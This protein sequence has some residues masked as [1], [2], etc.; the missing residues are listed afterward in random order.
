MN[1]AGVCADLIGTPEPRPSRYTSLRKAI[2]DWRELDFDLRLVAAIGVDPEIPLGVDGTLT[3]MLRY[4][5][6]EQLS[7]EMD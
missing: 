3:H 1:I 2:E 7:A 4:W 6:I 5:Q